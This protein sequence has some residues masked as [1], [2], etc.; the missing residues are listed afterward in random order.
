MR[1]PGLI[2]EVSQLWKQIFTRFAIKWFEREIKD[3]QE[4]Q[5]PMQP[6]L[7][8]FQ[9]W[10]IHRVSGQHRRLA[11]KLLLLLGYN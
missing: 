2:W 3:V 8:N 1:N 5:G 7:E 10:V 6:C 11:L 4:A 9:E